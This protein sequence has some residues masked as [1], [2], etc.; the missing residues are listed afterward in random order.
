MS[1][2]KNKIVKDS[3]K[4]QTPAIK[5]HQ[6][7]GKLSAAEIVEL[8]KAVGHEN[9]LVGGK[10]KCVKVHH[11][12]GNIS[13]GYFKRPNRNALALALSKRDGKKIVE[14]GE[15]L[16]DNCFVAGDEEIKTNDAMR[17]SAAMACYELIDFLENSSEDV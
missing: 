3:E 4:Q 15:A 12:N 1:E 5:K 6:H 14:A 8:K 16:L 9:L 7:I 11:E 10:L 13:Y 2:K 17:V